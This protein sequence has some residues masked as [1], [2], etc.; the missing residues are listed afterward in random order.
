MVAQLRRVGLQYAIFQIA[1]TKVEHDV[2]E[3]EKVRE[4][5]QAEPH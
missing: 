1:G 2:D 5:V 3:I 4:V